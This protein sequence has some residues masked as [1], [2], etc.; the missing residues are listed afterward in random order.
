MPQSYPSMGGAV[1]A[2]MQHNIRLAY[3]DPLP[4]PHT[5]L[6]ARALPHPSI[7][8]HSVPGMIARLTETATPSAVAG[9]VE[10]VNGALVGAVPQLT[11]LVAAAA[12]WT[13]VR[14]EFDDPHSSVTFET[15]T[16]LAAAHGMLRDVQEQLE[17]A[18]DGI[19]ACPAELTDPR[20]HKAVNV[21]RTRELPGDVL[22]A[23]AVAAAVPPVGR[24]PGVNRQ[25]AA[26]GAS[27]QAAAH[28]T[29]PSASSSEVPA[30]SSPPR[31]PRTR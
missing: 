9:I 7:D 12:D 4:A 1:A 11:E 3:G 29:T 20:H 27:P 14:L 28:R 16:R 26:R 23:E 6:Q 25:R 15:W 10:E 5:P 13:R 21:L 18:G 31:V 30:S 8:P 2:A 24:D 17:I 19:A 22:G